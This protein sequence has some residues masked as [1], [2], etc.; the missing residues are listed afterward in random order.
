MFHYYYICINSD[1]YHLTLTIYTCMHSYISDYTNLIHD[2]QSEVKLCW[3]ILNE[4]ARKLEI[5]N[6]M[7]TKRPSKWIS[8]T[9]H[10]EL[11]LCGFTPTAPSKAY[12]MCHN[13]FNISSIL[14]TLNRISEFY[15][16]LS[17][18]CNDKLFSI[19]LKMFGAQC[20]VEFQ[21]KISVG[22][23]IVNTFSIL[24]EI[25]EKKL[26]KMWMLWIH[27]PYVYL[28]R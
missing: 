17:N 21:L 2:L 5:H 9:M 16:S 28:F 24:D 3:Y 12:K 26:Q 8:A 10:Y 7:R 22:G 18:V 15:R 1:W 11:H 4:F 20:S 23:T 6:V 25:E 14:F 27:D 19:I 13:A